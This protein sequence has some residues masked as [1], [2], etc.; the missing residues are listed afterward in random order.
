MKTSSSLVLFL[1]LMTTSAQ[2]FA[3]EY[4]SCENDLFILR[5]KENS[6]PESRKMGYTKA[7]L[8]LQKKGG[9]PLEVI[10][11]FSETSTSTE[12]DSQPFEFNLKVP[13]NGKGVLKLEG[14][15]LDINCK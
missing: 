15:P 1:V 11:T 7:I 9:V 10:T 3:K 8:L 12:Y 14:H 2:V 13:K 5:F 4:V 6:E